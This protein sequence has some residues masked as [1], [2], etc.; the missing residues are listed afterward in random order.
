M[1][2]KK[3]PAKK[4][5]VSSRSGTAPPPLYR[6]RKGQSGN[7]RGRPP[8]PFTLTQ[9]LRDRMFSPAPREVVEKYWTEPKD[10][11]GKQ[12]VDVYVE[13]ALYAATR[14]NDLDSAAYKEIY[15]RLEGKAPDVPFDPAKAD[16][17]EVIEPATGDS[18]DQYK[19]ATGILR[20]LVRR[21]I[22]PANVFSRFQQ[23]ANGKVR[24]ITPLPNGKDKSSDDKDEDSAA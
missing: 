23:Q 5:G 20:E 3:P 2:K 11:K 12:W 21:E 17:P 15:L 24:D 9:R 4:P 22:L 13:A 1:K 7:P 8:L 6:W 19:L 18:A 16:G 14:K 10:Q